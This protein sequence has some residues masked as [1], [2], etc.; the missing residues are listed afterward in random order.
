MAARARSLA[1]LGPAGAWLAAL[2]FSSP[3]LADRVLILPA[4]PGA[5]EDAAQR[6]ALEIEMARSLASLGHALVPEAE[7]KA[8]LAAVA[9]GVADTSEEYRAAGTAAKADWVIGGAVEPAVITQRVELVAYLVSLGRVE[10]VA[11]EVERARAAEQIQEML[12][13]LVRPE[14]IGAGELPWE[15][16]RAQPSQVA[17]PPPPPPPPPKPVAAPPPPAPEGRREGERVKLD[18]AW[19]SEDVWPP[20]ANSRRGFVAAMQGIS[21]AAVRPSGAVGDAWAIVGQVRGGYAIGDSGLEVF[22]QIGGNLVGPRALWTEIGARLLL[23]PS[24]HRTGGSLHGLAFHVGPEITAG[25]FFRFPASQTSAAGTDF[26]AGV[27]ARPTIG[28]TLSMALQVTPSVQLDAQLGNL[29]WV[30]A[31]DGSLLLFGATLGAGLRF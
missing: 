6:N 26:S 25:G 23:T 19:T 13:V 21:I 1:A 15:R 20:Y 29:R 27:D 11:R 5:E 18:Y 14:G 12:G 28:A 2:L 3:A 8:A 9:D 10:S 30:P 22:A 31:G 17:A 16:P 7:A 24:V 4:R